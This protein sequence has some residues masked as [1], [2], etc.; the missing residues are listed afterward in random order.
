MIQRSA[1]R[2]NC[3]Q[4]LVAPSFS[5]CQLKRPD[6]ALGIA[7]I[8]G[9]SGSTHRAQKA[10]FQQCRARRFC[11][12]LTA[13]IRV[14]NR[15]GHFKGHLL[16]GG[17]DQFRRHVVIKGQRENMPGALPQGKAAAHFGSMCQRDFK[18]IR[19]DDFLG[20]F[21]LLLRLLWWAQQVGHDAAGFPRVDGLLALT[22]RRQAIFFHYPLDPIFPHLEQ[23]SQ[24]AVAQRVIKFVSPFDSDGDLLVILRLLSMQIE[25]AARSAQ[26]ASDLAFGI[27]AVRLAQLT[28]P[29]HL[30]CRAYLPTSPET[31]F[32]IS[33]GTVN[34][35]MIFFSSSGDSPGAYP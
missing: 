18:N 32:R 19:E 6:K 33:F 13:L 29:F 20:V 35:P 26:G 27:G 34:S 7:V 22:T 5:S 9:R 30:L 1:A 2:R 11:P 17:D 24:L 10:F 16:D 3:P 25:S 21:L 31:F 23:H 14:K 15:A 8:G 4:R 12:I 28:R